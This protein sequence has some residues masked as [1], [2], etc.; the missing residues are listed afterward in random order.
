[1]LAPGSEARLTG[2]QTEHLNGAK[3]RIVKY[4]AQK[5]R[6]VVDFPCGERSRA[7]FKQENLVPESEPESV[8]ASGGGGGASSSAPGGVTSQTLLPGLPTLSDPV[9]LMRGAINLGMRQGL[10]TREASTLQY[11]KVVATF[12][13]RVQS[14]GGGGGGGGPPGG[15][16][17]G[18]R[19][20]GGP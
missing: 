13:I 17:G 7:A 19:C 5:Q 8:P 6:Y 2:L 11:W 15:G 20:A 12:N 3:V 9:P 14:G 4:Q 18:L 10:L 1:M 16:G